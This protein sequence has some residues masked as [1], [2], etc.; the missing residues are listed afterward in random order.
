[1]KFFKCDISSIKARQWFYWGSIVAVT[2][3]HVLIYVIF[4]YSCD[5][6][7]Y[8]SAI[9]DYCKGIDMSFP[10]SDLWACWVDHYSNDNIRL[11][12]VVF[13]LALLLPK[14]I[15]SLLS[16]LLV[17]AMVWQSG[18]LAGITWRN[19]LLM[20]ILIMLLMFMLPWYEE[21]LTLCFAFNY[22]WASALTLMMSLLF[23]RDDRQLSVVVSLLL[24]MA[25]GAWHEGFAAPLLLGFVVYCMMSRH[26]I[27][28][29][30]VAMMVGLVVGLLWLASAP[31][32]QMNVGYK[33][34]QLT[35]GAVI[36]KLLLYHLPMLLMIGSVVV[37]MTR[38][39][40]RGIFR[41][42]MLVA[43]IVVGISGSAL[44]FITNVGVR[45]GWIG[46]LYCIIAT[47]NMWHL[48]R[49]EKFVPMWSVAKRVAVALLSVFL[50][51]HYVVVV[52]YT[53]RIRGENDYV[54]EQYQKS[55]DG[56]VFAD[57]TYDYEA[58]PLAWKKPYFEIFTYTWVSF[59]IDKY[60]SNSEKQLRVIPCCLRNVSNL[61]ADKMAGDNPFLVYNGYYYAPATPEI[62]LPECEY[63]DV[64]FGVTKKRL[65]FSYFYFTTPSGEQYYFAFPQRATMHLWVGEIKSINKVR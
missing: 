59:W 54:L 11:S 33:T 34:A 47:I 7:W 18:K 35:I 46:Y 60:Y 63:Y 45:T 10:A 44:N 51:L 23:W 40:T 30:R 22:I 9:A 5:D 36:N 4:P 41:N 48:M 43:L 25:V 56:L 28:K 57:V 37:A 32:L 12:N 15:P 1:M 19:P 3:S 16:G 26:S 24:G 61:K 49:G 42:P 53:I 50:L 2:L 14:F 31:G 29:S 58:S 13:S 39:A 65:N 38:R 55:P 21:M 8:M 20:T 6:Y 62:E 17:G 27:T 52:Y 64:D